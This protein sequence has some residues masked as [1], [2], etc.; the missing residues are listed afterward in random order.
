MAEGVIK[1]TH[2]PLGREV[3]ET[4]GD[5]EEEGIVGGRMSE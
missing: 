1:G 2:L 5:T 3:S 4:G